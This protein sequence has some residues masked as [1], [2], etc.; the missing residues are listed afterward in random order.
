MSEVILRA[1][2]VNVRFGG[3]RALSDLDVEVRRGEVLGIVG[4]NGAGK[5]TLFNVLAGAIRPTSGRVILR[6]RDITTKR[7]DQ[8]AKLG[9]SRTFQ[10]VRP[11]VDE[12]LRRNVAVA[13]LAVG[14]GRGHALDVA[15]ELLEQVGLADKADHL[16]SDLGHGERKRLELARAL[17]VRP[18]VL[19]LDEV[20]AGLNPSEVHEIVELVRGLCAAS[21]TDLVIIEHL[22][23]AVR[24]L[25]ERVVVLDAGKVLA[26][27]APDHV[28][29]D[30]RVIEAYLGTK[31]AA[32]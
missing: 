29:E 4:P 10:T 28:F 2:K 5:S 27:G 26:E 31:Y 20:M 18:S 8:R 14:K 19:M 17:A 21:E 22:L 7:D 25:A 30:P 15:D 23:S 11:F 9:I 12:T 32:S 3:L 1:E 13:A 16:A 24:S 6:G